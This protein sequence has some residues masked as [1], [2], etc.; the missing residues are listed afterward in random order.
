VVASPLPSVFLSGYRMG[1][2]QLG[3]ALYDGISELALASVS[4]TYPREGALTVN[5]IAPKRDVV[6]SQHGL[7]F[8]RRWSFADAPRLDRIIL[9]GS[10]SA[11]D[12]AA[13]EGW[14]QGGRQLAVERV[15]QGGGHA[16]DVTLNDMAGRSGC[17]IVTDAAYQLE[18]PI[19]DALACAPRYQLDLIVRLSIL[20]LL[21]LA[22]APL[23]EIR[24]AARK[25]RRQVADA[26]AA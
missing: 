3:V 9:P 4:D 1:N 19:G 12:T 18:Y 22:L 14:A 20:A 11:A 24:R 13:F 10:P 26:S 17:A 5:T 15:R 8:I 23:I 21:G 7:A 6:L 16:Y 2:S 25:Q